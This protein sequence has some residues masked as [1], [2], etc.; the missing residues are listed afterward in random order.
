MLLFFFSGHL[1]VGLYLHRR[2]PDFFDPEITLRLRKLSAGMAE[3]PGRPLALFLGSSR[4]FL[5]LRT[6]SLNESQTQL[7]GRPL[8]FNFALTGGGPVSERLVLH[9]VLSKGI[10]PHW[11][12]VEVWP[13]FLPQKGYFEEESIIFCRDLYWSDLRILARLYHQTWDAFCKL[14]AETVTPLLHYR[15]AVLNHYAPQVV[16]TGLLKDVQVKEYFVAHVDSYG[17]MGFQDSLLGPSSLGPA[18]RRHLLEKAQQ[19]TRPVF[20]EFQVS[21]ISRQA[22]HELLEECR[23]NDIR[24]AFLL[25]PEHSLVRSWYPL[26]QFQFLAYLT[27]LSRQYHAPVLD[28]RGW[29]AD[30]DIPDCYHLT[31]QATKIFSERFDREVY[32]PL[33]QGR[34]LAPELLLDGT[35]YP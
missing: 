2:H 31:P 12:F 10:R 35:N 11:L 16:P 25:M 21:D 33:L 19:S 15:V 34:P 27:Q 28:T 22:L 3:A 30:E 1:L 24:V 23:A 14:F 32:R 13:P 5:G 18:E 8:A 9:R 17:W 26:M 4:V 29:Q 7:Q 20:E 6:S